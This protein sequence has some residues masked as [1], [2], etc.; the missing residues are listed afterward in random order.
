MKDHR[1]EYIDL[2]LSYLDDARRACWY[3][4]RYTDDYLTSSGVL[5]VHE[6]LNL[7]DNTHKEVENTFLKHREICAKIEEDM[8]KRRKR[9]NK[10]VKENEFNKRIP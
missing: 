10:R 7:I 9:H 8:I 4:L 2:C 5:N 1:E 3:G 6:L